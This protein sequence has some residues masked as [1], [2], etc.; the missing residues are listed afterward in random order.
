MAVQQNDRRA[1]AAVPYPQPRR[2]D[3]EVFQDE[4]VEHARRVTH[5]YD[6]DAAP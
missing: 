4:T 1:A 3:I 5:P 2:T 6:D